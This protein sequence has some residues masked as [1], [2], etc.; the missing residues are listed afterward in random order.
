MPDVLEFDAP[1]RTEAGAS[2]LDTLQEPWIV[3]LDGRTRDI[4]EH[5]DFPTRS[6]Y[7]ARATSQ[8]CRE[9]VVWTCL[10]GRNSCVLR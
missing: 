1:T 5:A 8:F 2:L 3:F 9:F 7:C 6:L 10:L 4:G